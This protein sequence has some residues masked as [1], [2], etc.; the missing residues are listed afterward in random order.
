MA[1]DHFNS[2]V[3]P[4]DG[5]QLEG[6]NG[7]FE[8]LLLVTSKHFHRREPTGRDHLA[9]GWLIS[10]MCWVIV[11]VCVRF[12]LSACVSVSVC[13]CVGTNAGRM[14]GEGW[15]SGEAMAGQHQKKAG[16]ASGRCHP[17]DGAE[18]GAEWCG[19]AG[20]EFPPDKKSRTD[21]K[22]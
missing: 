22:L 18:S 2:V 13:V 15:D 14:L 1:I 6:Y 4:W 8:A 17:P 7:Y 11:S 21:L 19:E 9:H 10:F 12:S 3:N 20:K 5:S 16:P